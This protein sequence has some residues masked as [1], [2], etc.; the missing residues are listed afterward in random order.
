MQFALNRDSV[1]AGDDTVSHQRSLD[2]DPDRTLGALVSQALRDY[3]LP[4]VMGEV[5][6]LVEVRLGRYETDEHGTRHSPTSCGL[7]L[8]HVPYPTREATV[9]ALNRHFLQTPV[10]E[11]ARQARGGEVKLHFRYITEGQRQRPDE[12]AALYG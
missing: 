9:T 7:A 4:Y 10:G 3:P 2:V 1:H 11:L 12:F 5:S 6:W 8:L